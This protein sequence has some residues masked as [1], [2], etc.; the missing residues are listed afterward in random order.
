MNSVD[1]I[2]DKYSHVD[3]NEQGNLCGPDFMDSDDFNKAAREYGKQQAIAFAEWIHQN[4]WVYYPRQTG[5]WADL[6]T[7][8][9]VLSNEELY[10]LFLQQS[11]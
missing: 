10:T 2:F 7:E 3:R 1:E 11:K 9:R 5:Y 6:H 8:G 4:D